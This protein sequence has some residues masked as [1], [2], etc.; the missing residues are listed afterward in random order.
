MFIYNSYCT[1]VFKNSVGLR[2]PVTESTSFD[3]YLTKLIALVTIQKLSLAYQVD[4]HCDLHNT[5]GK[6][7][8]FRLALYYI[9]LNKS[10]YGVVKGFYIMSVVLKME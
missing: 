8:N 4:V 1:V 2:I 9:F 5:L 3:H 7:K 6:V 10:F